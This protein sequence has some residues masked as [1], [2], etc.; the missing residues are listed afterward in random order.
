MKLSSKKK[1]KTK[2]QAIQLLNNLIEKIEEEGFFVAPKDIRFL[3]ITQN[4]L[5]AMRNSINHSEDFFE[6]FFKDKTK[7]E[8]IEWIEDESEKW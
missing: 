2:N 3:Q 1:I 4:N 6:S 8:I 5:I 7:E